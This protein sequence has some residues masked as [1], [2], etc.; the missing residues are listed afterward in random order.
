MKHIIQAYRPERRS[1]Q[2]VVSYFFF[3]GSASHSVASLLS[4]LLHQ[5]LKTTPST[6]S[7]EIFSKFHQ[8]R[9]DEISDSV[10]DID[11][12]MES[13]LLLVDKSTAQGDSIF[14]I[15]DALDECDDPAKLVTLLCRLNDLNPSRKLRICL[16]SRPSNLS[17]P[18]AEIRLED[19]NFLDIQ[20]YLSENLLALEDSL[21]PASNVKQISQTL[22]EKA[23]G[24]FL[25]A[26]LT[27]SQLRCD[28]HLKTPK[29]EQHS[30][31]W[32]PATLDAAYETILKQLWSRHDI[33]RRMMAQDAFTLVLCAQRPLSILELR[34]ALAAMHYDPDLLSPRSNSEL[35]DWGRRNKMKRIQDEASLDM[36]MQLMLLCGGLLEVAPPQAKLASD[37]TYTEPILQFVHRSARDY[38]RERGPYVL[39]GDNLTSKLSFPDLKFTDL[40]ACNAQYHYRVAWIC[41]LYVDHMYMHFNLLNTETVINSAAFL[42]YSLWFGMVHLSLAERARVNPMKNEM[43]HFSQFQKGFVDQWAFLH[44]RI[45]KDQ[46]LFEPHKT[47]AVH[48][49]SYYG[50]PWFDTGLWGANL[51][52]IDEEDRYGRTPLSLAAA[53]G[54]HHICEILLDNGADMSHR[55]CIY[56]QTPLSYAAAYGHR[57]V[58]EL[59]LSKGSDYEDSSSGVTP[60]WLA[61]RSGHLDIVELLLQAGYRV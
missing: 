11:V 34:S 39:E 49:M 3:G 5:L 27:I 42:E 16:S 7:F 59:L 35:N 21:L 8:R 43:Y 29:S 48:V 47:K 41:L 55:D 18:G 51:A 30:T 28:G 6:R 33:S 12:L 22:A 32:L 20:Q 53:M 46:K 17:V 4:S 44:N 54:H 50:L 1:S 38:F 45:F 15:I 24:V 61:S 40:Q 36:S 19:N 60:L 26:S 56:G 13:L 23:K 31:S 2:A 25:W 58:V 37:K 10:M 52:E 14:F 9:E 57:E